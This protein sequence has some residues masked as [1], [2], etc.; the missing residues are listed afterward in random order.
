MSR[1]IGRDESPREIYTEEQIRRVITACGIDIES[2]IDSDY[3]I[4]CPYHNNYRTPAG[5]V[6]KDTGHFYCFACQES[7]PLIDVVMHVT[8]RSFFEASRLIASKKTET[9]IAADLDNIL[10]KPVQ[11]EEF[12]PMLIQRLHKQLL[13]SDRGA[14]YFAKRGIL[15]NS[16]M[17]YMLGYSE[18]QDMVTVPV[19]TPDGLCIG[20]VGR[21]VEGKEFK[22]TP[23]LQKSKTLFNLHRAKRFDKVFIVESSFDAIRIEQCGGH[24]VATL[25][26]S[27]SKEQIRLL[28]QHFNSIIVVAD[29]DD[30]GTGMRDKLKSAFGTAMIAARLPD[31]VKDI[32]DMSDGQIEKFIQQFDDELE[33]ILNL[34]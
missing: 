14:G 27:V 19:H 4:Y 16:M 28:K 3:L 22:N 30:A 20:F 7:R 15:R 31:E 8:D 26:A 5:E 1:W 6:A 25:G 10:D 17:F 21:S 34:L 24:A 12:D 2:E 32:S 13:Q 23:G 33:Y 11:F 9:D 29:N 18:A